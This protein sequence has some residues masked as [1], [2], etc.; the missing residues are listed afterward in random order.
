M[1]FVELRE[2]ILF[3]FSILISAFSAGVIW[4]KLNAKIDQNAEDIKE[5]ASV[6]QLNGM[7]G[8]ID[9][10]KQDC[11]TY[12]GSMMEFRREL[13]EYR[14]EARES[15]SVLNRIEQSNLEIAARLSELSKNITTMD[16]ANS[17]RLTRLETVVQ[18]EK[19]LGSSIPTE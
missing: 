17:N 14:Q 1:N 8:R 7:S 19:K 15:T 18:V 4:T 9:G 3:G 5:K 10:V 6:D 12:N 2:W 11:A 13:G 16:K